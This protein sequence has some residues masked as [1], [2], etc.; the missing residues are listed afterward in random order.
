[1]KEEIDARDRPAIVWGLPVP[2]YGVAVGYEDN[3]YLATTCYGRIEDPIPYYRLEAPGKIQAL[4]FRDMAQ[5]KA[6]EIEREVV[7]RAV[8]FASMTRSD[9]IWIMGPEAWDAWADALQGLSSIEDYWSSYGGN[10]Y[11]ALCVRE[12]RYIAAEFLKRLTAAKCSRHL[13]IET[14]TRSKLAIRSIM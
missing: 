2:D 4:F 13:W 3:S 1:M 10:N 11:V 12:S 7:E 9:G 14:Y 6:E 8:R 5:P